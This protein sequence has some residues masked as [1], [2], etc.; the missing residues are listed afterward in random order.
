MR[1]PNYLG[2][3]MLYLTG[4]RNR[5]LGIIYGGQAPGV[6]IWIFDFAA[7]SCTLAY[8]FCELWQ[9]GIMAHNA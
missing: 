8:I 4:N 7:T 2:R 3:C 5:D 9:E 1:Y 6:K